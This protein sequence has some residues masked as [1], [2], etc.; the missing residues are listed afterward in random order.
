MPA[1]ERPERPGRE[2]AKS[3]LR[4]PAPSPGRM[5][6]E[7][8]LALQRTMGN[9]AVS[10]LIS[11]EEPVQEE[12]PGRRSAVESVLSSPG[13]PLG[14]SVR[15]DMEARLGADFSSVRLHTGPAARDSAAEIGARAYTSGDHVVIGDGGGDS[16]T[17]AHELT[18]VI[19]QRQGPVA[20]TDNGS[21]LSI[22]D[23]SDHFER[24]A[25]A[26]AHR[27]LSA[28]APAQP[29]PDS[30]EDRENPEVQRSGGQVLQRAADRNLSE[31]MTT[32]YHKVRAAGR[33]RVP[34]KRAGGSKRNIKEILERTG[35]ELLR[36]LKAMESRKNE[37]SARK[38]GSSQELLL[39]RAMPNEEADEILRWHQ[40][41]KLAGTEK[42]LLGQGEN[43]DD[44][45]T[46]FREA[47]K[48]P[49]SEVGVIPVKKHL[50]AWDQAYSYYTPSGGT[51][52]ANRAGLRTK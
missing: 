51:L 35:P 23:P 4:S 20:G 52:P 6:P 14:D 17:L 31:V 10:R 45:D 42:W 49:D 39:Y 13:T 11:E 5:S 27:A 12:A 34:E 9:A 46:R 50:G 21:G 19:Q 18:H 44:I 25:E 16:H 28:P 24:E 3:Q 37:T 26:N 30:P 7:T 47:S 2:S 1:R 36:E 43:R 48:D 29:A 22:S 15:T 40:G 41:G 38:K 33:E 8:A 32:D